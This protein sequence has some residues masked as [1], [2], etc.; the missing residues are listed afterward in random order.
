MADRMTAKLVL[1]TLTLAIATGPRRN[2][3]DIS[4]TTRSPR[5][6]GPSR[7]CSIPPGANAPRT[8]KRAPAG[9]PSHLAFGGSGH[10]D[11]SNSCPKRSAAEGDLRDHDC[12]DH[13]AGAGLAWPAA[14]VATMKAKAATAINRIMRFSFQDELN[15]LVVAYGSII[16]DL[17]HSGFKI[18]RTSPIAAIMQRSKQLR[19]SITASARAS[20][21]GGTSRRP[22]DFAVRNPS[23][24]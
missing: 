8:P 15:H 24:R 22:R 9:M 2:R 6:R 11:T 19:Y 23:S 20:S 13:E 21:D 10:A 7:W 5:R 4:L 12:P 16:A 1:A 18:S 17:Y 14:D 3:H